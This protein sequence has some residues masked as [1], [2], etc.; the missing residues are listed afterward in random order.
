MTKDLEKAL[1]EAS[2]LSDADQNALAEAILNEIRTNKAWE[3]AF[4]T[5]QD[6]LGRLADEALEE[7]RSGSTR[8]LDPKK[9]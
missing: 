3:E 9:L 2:K 6:E 1:K 7:H 4:A 8:P 5:S